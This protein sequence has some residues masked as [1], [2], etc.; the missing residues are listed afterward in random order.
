M[1]INPLT[2][3]LP[4]WQTITCCQIH[5]T[6]FSHWLT[7]LTNQSTLL[8]WLFWPLPTS[9]TLKMQASP[10]VLASVSSSWLAWPA[11]WCHLLPWASLI[12]QWW[13]PNLCSSASDSMLGLQVYFTTVNI[14]LSIVNRYFIPLLPSCHPPWVPTPT[15][16]T[17][18]LLVLSIFSSRLVPSPSTP[19]RESESH[20][21]FLTFHYVPHKP[22]LIRAHI[23]NS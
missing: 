14:F 19:N 9:L 3:L 10:G 23:F 20:S 15:S 5:W 16:T 18:I 17:N 22:I 13:L 6:I 2:M 11:E 8:F 4:R 12:Y 1:A 21:R 7:S